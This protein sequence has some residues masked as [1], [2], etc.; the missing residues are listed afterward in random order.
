MRYLSTGHRIARASA[1]SS[2]H[3]VSTTI[4]SQYQHRTSHSKLVVH[5]LCQYRKSPSS[6]AAY[7]IP[8]LHMA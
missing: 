1:N 6:I 2:L 8:V 7:A 4:R 3:D 5:T